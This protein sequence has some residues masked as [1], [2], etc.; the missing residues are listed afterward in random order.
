MEIF[1]IKQ[2]NNGWTMKGPRAKDACDARE[3]F[4]PTLHAVSDILT[5]W[6]IEGFT[7]AAARAEKKYG[8][9]L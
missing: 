7:K 4:L 6:H 1:L 5:T 3:L 8:G 2:I 9:K